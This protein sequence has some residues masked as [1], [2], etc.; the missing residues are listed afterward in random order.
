M[1]SSSGA[2]FPEFVQIPGREQAMGIQFNVRYNVE[3]D[4]LQGNSVLVFLKLQNPQGHYRSHAWQVLT[5]SA[6]ATES[7]HYEDR[8]STDVNSFGITGNKIVS[9]RQVIAPGQLLSAVSPHGLSP[10]LQPAAASLAQSKLTPAQCGVMNETS[11]FIPFS[12]NWYVNDRPVATMPDV[13]A[14]MTVGFEYLPS[15]YFVV[16]MRPAAGQTYSLESFQDMTQYAMPVSATEV[17]VTLH[18]SQ[19]AWRFDF[20]AR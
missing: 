8:I 17:D 2:V 19:D 4:D 9:G 3:T 7:F 13:D 15:L 12:C 1:D 6:G 18:R 20:A 16:A 14:N 5:G 10:L 11:P